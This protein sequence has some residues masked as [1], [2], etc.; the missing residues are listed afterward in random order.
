MIKDKLRKNI[1]LLRKFSISSLDS[2]SSFLDE[3]KEQFILFFFFFIEIGITSR[4]SSSSHISFGDC[5][6][7][8]TISS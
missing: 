1:T 4:P 6:F 2:I 7:F 5:S 3:Q 8:I